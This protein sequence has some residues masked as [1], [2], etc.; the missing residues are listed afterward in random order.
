M[1]R[2]MRAAIPSAG[3]FGVLVHVFTE[4][5]I[6]G[7]RETAERGLMPLTGGSAAITE[8]ELR[9]RKKGDR[10]VVWVFL[11]ETII[12]TKMTGRRRFANSTSSTW[13]RCSSCSATSRHEP[14]MKLRR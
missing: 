11:I 10:E 13:Q 2:R 12:R 8:D 7:V 4:K 14:R 1:K 9:Y 3:P 6:E 5:P